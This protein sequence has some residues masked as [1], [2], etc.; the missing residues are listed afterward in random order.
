MKRKT[1]SFTGV[2]PIFTGSP[3]IVPGGFN[4]DVANQHFNPGMVI[5]GGSL[6]IYD[7]AKRTVQIVKTASVVEVDS[8]DTK[9]VVLKVDEFYHPIFAVGDK[10]AKAGAI[11]GTFAAAAQITSVEHKENSFVITLSA[12]ISGLA[13]GDALVEVVKDGSGNAAEIGKANSV[14]I[15]DIVVSEFETGVDVTADT[16]QYA[17]YERRV[18]VIPASQKDANGS[19]L[20]VNPHVKL[21]QS[22]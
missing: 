7:E 4:L 16:M 1:A 13:E 22:Y 21:T 15:A 17:L 6:A 9:K 3:A 8:E 12:A 11:S 20:A 14:T 19:F 5:P 2:R 18:P 10:V